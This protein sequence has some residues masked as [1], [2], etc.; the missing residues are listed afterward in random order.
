MNNVSDTKTQRIRNKI[1]NT[2]KKYKK[3]KEDI[4]QK[5][6]NYVVDKDPHFIYFMINLVHV[7]LMLVYFIYPLFLIKNKEVDIFLIYLALFI[8][9][10]RTLLRGECFLFL[11]EKWKIDSNYKP[12]QNKYGPGWHYLGKVINFDFYSQESVNQTSYHVKTYLLSVIIFSYLVL[13]SVNSK[14]NQ[15]A[16]ILTFSFF[17]LVNLFYMFKPNKN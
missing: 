2:K 13:R 17:G 10:H 11:L 6:K 4:I 3:M 15:M 1:Q 8:M 5:Y 9:F 14:Q 12:G 16:L 7:I